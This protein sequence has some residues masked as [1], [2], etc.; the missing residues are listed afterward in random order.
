MDN[1]IKSIYD[2]NNQIIISGH[3]NPDYDSICSCLSLAL[4]L[5]QLN[6]NIKIYIEEK[7]I[8]KVKIF[9][10]DN[11][12]SCDIN[13]EDFSLIILDVNRISR[14]PDEING[15]YKKA[16]IVINIDH[17][18]GNDTN[19][20]IVLSNDKK[21]S[22]CELIYDLVSNMKIKLNKKIAELLYIGI[23][24][25]T[26][27]FS[28][29]CTPE[30]FLTVS[31]LLKKN[32]DS[33]YLTNKFYL[34]KSNNELLV[35]SEMIKNIK[36]DNFHYIIINPN[37]YPYNLV[38]YISISKQCIPIVFSNK[39]INV[40]MVILNYG[41]KNKGEIRSKGNINVEKLAKLLTGGGHTN[42]AGFSNNKTIKEIIDITKNYLKG[43]KNE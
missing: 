7:D 33:T 25:D 27:S 14:L 41:Y 37:D 4:S 39:D 30:T 8:E 15:L 13:Y 10:L 23:V 26:N 34:E 3:K 29:S 35:I 17:H 36:Y 1:L 43:D 20:D 9:N 32:I 42:A 38:D 21:S 19:A 40:L 6:K 18:N 31:K 22:T 12:F 5:S 16:K 24:S 11:L 28:N 2:I